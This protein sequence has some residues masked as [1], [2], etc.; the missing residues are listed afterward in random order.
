MKNQELFVEVSNSLNEGTECR[1]ASEIEITKARSVKT[2]LDKI[3]TEI[4]RLE[5]LKEKLTTGC[6]HRVTFDTAGWPY[7]IRTCFYCGKEVKKKRI[8]LTREYRLQKREQTKSKPNGIWLM[9]T[10]R[11]LVSV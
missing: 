9:M 10:L 1:Q 3:E 8:F 2:D 4:N 11:F 7:D 5:R 6:D